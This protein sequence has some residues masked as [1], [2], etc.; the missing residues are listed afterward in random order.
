MDLGIIALLVVL[1]VTTGIVVT[2]GRRSHPTI[3]VG[4]LHSL[5]GTMAFSE[6]A[7]VD[8]TLL[9]I[10]ELNKVLIRLLEAL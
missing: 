9:A 7:V 3:R 4:I 8:A 5:S 2:I 6:S 1:A 10:E